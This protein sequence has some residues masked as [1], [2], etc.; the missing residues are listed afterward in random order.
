MST[1]AAFAACGQASFTGAGGSG[2]SA[3]GDGG[4]QGGEAGGG[5]STTIEVAPDA[6]DAGARAP[7]GWKTCGDGGC[8]PGVSETCVS[9]ALDGGPT[10]CKLTGAEGSFGPMCLIAGRQAEGE[11]CASAADCAA[12]L[13]CVATS[14]GQV[15]RPYCCGESDSCAFGSVCSP[16][17][18]AEAEGVFVPMCQPVAPCDLLAQPGEAGA[19]ATGL[20]CT[21]AKPDGTTWCAAPGEGKDGEACP[22]AAGHV[23]STLTLTC[24]RLCDLAADSCEGG[25]C[26]GGA[27]G[28]PEGVGVCVGGSP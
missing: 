23:C 26:Q 8:T 1:S 5:G 28:L 12:G 14:A 16:S 4:A 2:A 6:G 15:C 10:S 25:S 24:L 13:G 27:G 22:C 17:E 3:G 7:A 19:C 21:L 18:A 20:A 9:P 11:P